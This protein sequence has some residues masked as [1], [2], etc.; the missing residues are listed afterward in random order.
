[1]IFQGLTPGIFA[2]FSDSIGRR[3]TYMICFIVY[4]AA[5]IG[6]AV[7]NTYW[8]LMLL[9]AIQATG[10]SATVALGAGV[11]A[12]I[13]TSQERGGYLGFFGVGPLTGPSLGPVIGGALAQRLGW[14]S[15]FWFLAIFSGVF[16][17]FVVLFLPET[18][19]SIVGNGSIRPTSLWHVRLIDIIRHWLH[20]EKPVVNQGY[21][22]ARNA[23]SQRSTLAPKKKTNVLESF[24]IIFQK[25]VSLVLFIP[26][27]HYTVY[28]MGITIP[29]YQLTVVTTS[30]PILF[31]KHYGLDS[32]RIG[33][34]YL[35]I[36][37]GTLIGSIGY[38]KIL[39]RDWRI[40]EKRHLD[41]GG[42]KPEGPTDLYHFPLEI[43]RMRSVWW[44][45]LAFW[46]CCAGYGWTIQYSVSLAAPL[47]LQ[48]IMGCTMVCI[49]SC[50]QALLID[51]HPGRSASAAASVGSLALVLTD[52]GQLNI[53]RCWLGAGGSAV[54]QPMLTGLNAGWTYSLLAILCAICSFP[55]ILVER[56]WGTK[57]R[58]QREDK[59]GRKKAEKEGKTRE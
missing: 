37:A 19:R 44:P 30:T 1:M 26:A 57:W 5:N 13:A 51:L 47:T 41:A 56:R 14:R 46:G 17:G 42:R 52:S 8:L 50:F 3:P 31:S 38:G 6:L 23:V 27:I 43:A 36:G 58:R 9:R 18:L 12:D 54:T 28:V 32:F 39:D 7:T 40:I 48:A 59:K 21:V 25:D 2:A 10:N 55:P 4:I 49:M 34:T 22:E 35:A 16:T 33:L 29:L 53:V 20:R 15:I 11:I 24:K 45:L